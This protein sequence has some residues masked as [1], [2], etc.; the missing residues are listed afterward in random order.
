MLAASAIAEL[1][2]FLRRRFERVPDLA[3]FGVF[4]ALVALIPVLTSD[5]YILRVSVDTLIFA[6][7]V[8]GLNVVVGWGGIA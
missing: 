8:L 2:G 1:I 7:L 3:R 5:Q 4:I 6:L